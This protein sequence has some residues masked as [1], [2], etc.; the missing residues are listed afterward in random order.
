MLTIPAS[1]R[2]IDVAFGPAGTDCMGAGAGGAAGVT[3]LG[4]ITGADWIGLGTTVPW[5]TPPQP[6]LGEATLTP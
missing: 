2:S 3:G 6:Q 1:L 5:M 4:V